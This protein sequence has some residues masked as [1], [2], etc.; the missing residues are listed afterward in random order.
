MSI[1]GNSDFQDPPKVSLSDVINFQVGTKIL[2]TS[3]AKALQEADAES[4]VIV[5]I[6]QPIQS[7]QVE[8]SNAKVRRNTKKKRTS[9]NQQIRDMIQKSIRTSKYS[10][11]SRTDEGIEN[12][13][14]GMFVIDHHRETIKELKDREDKIREE[15]LRKRRKFDET[16]Q[17]ASYKSSLDQNFQT[18]STQN[19]QKSRITAH[20]DFQSQKPFDIIKKEEGP[21]EEEPIIAELLHNKQSEAE[22]E[23]E[24][25]NNEVIS[26]S[27]ISSTIPEAKVEPTGNILAPPS[28]LTTIHSSSSISPHCIMSLPPDFFE[29]FEKL[30]GVMMVQQNSSGITNVTVVMNRPG[31]PLDKSEVL[32]QFFDTNPRSCNVELRGSPEAVHYFQKYH[33]EFVANFRESKLAL[34]LNIRRPSLLQD[35]KITRKR[36]R[37]E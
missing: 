2:Q 11:K 9:L 7:T 6:H 37:D 35:K 21:K 25:D 14:N 18:E 1:P 24:L 12:K 31:S 17:S 8:I 32:L 16:M 27:E 5:N 33:G 10:K 22:I 13:E 26:K 34:Q 19:L 15:N 3:F 28:A 4:V 36:K 29:L 23:R 30:V 20:K